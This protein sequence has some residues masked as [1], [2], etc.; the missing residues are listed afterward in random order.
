MEAQNCPVTDAG[1]KVL[2]NNIVSI[3]TLDILCH[4]VTK[5][6]IRMVLESFPVLKDLYCDFPPQLLIELSRIPLE[7]MLFSVSKI[8]LSSRINDKELF[9]L[10]KLKTLS[11]LHISWMLV[12]SDELTFNMEI[13]P[14][15]KKF[16]RTLTSLS[17]ENL[18]INIQAIFENCH[19]L[20]SLSLKFIV[21]SSNEKL[22]DEPKP[23]KRMKIG[24]L[25]KN[26]KELK[27]NMC[28]DLTSEDLNLLLTSPALEKLTLKG[29]DS[30]NDTAFLKAYNIHQFRN[31]E[32]LKLYSEN[33]TKSVIDMFMN[34]GNPLKI[35]EIC[36][37]H[38]LS[39]RDIWKW[40]SIVHQNSW[41][42]VF[43]SCFK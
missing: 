32:R 27:L 2:C 38:S 7:R 5:N 23:S 42:C 11:E 16:G 31:L 41:D 6:G 29:I 35:I 37:C 19:K 33:V 17:I 39:I 1:I 25:L 20:E 43:L 4:G 13:L 40:N 21:T 14:I 12:D 30:V 24:P 3:E 22:E 9:E 18:N 34:D 26:L 36:C 8:W 28:N 15:L 10:L